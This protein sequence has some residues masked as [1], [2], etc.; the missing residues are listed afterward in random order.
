[1]SRL[2]VAGGLGAAPRWRRTALEVLAALA[3]GAALAA[4]FPAPDIGPLALVAL[5]PLLLLVETTRPVKAAA[6]G[7][8]AG[9]TFFG[10]HLLWIAQFLSWT[11]AVAWLAWGA[12]SA[13]QAAFIAAFFALVPAT[14]R[15]G[16]W[17]LLVLPAC[18][19]VLELVRAHH[20]MGGFPWGLLAISQHDAGPLLPLAR[21]IGGFGL[22]AVIVA[23]NLAVAFWLN[24]LLA[25]PAL[26]GDGG[27]LAGRGQRPQGPEEPRS[28]GWGR[29]AALAGLPVLAAGLLAARVAVPAAPA[30]SGPPMDVV[31]VQGGLRG[32][33]GL[34]QGLTTERVFANH[35]RLTETVALIPGDPP[36][37]VVWGEGAADADP[38][39]SPDRL[40]EVGRAA[41]A[42]KA[43]ILLGATTRVD[44]THRATEGLLFTAGGQLA[45]RYRKRRLVPF[46]EFVPLGG[47]LG[48]L[49][50]ATREGVPYDKVPGRRLE[51][52]LIDGVPVGTLI[53][54]ESA[55]PGDAR[56]LT[57][58][59]ARVLLIMTN[60]ASFGT[61]AGPRQHLAAGQLRAVEAGRTIVQAAVTGIS[62]V[63]EPTGATRQETGLYRETVLRAGL[64]PRDGRTLYVRYGRGIEAGLVGVAVGG[65]VLSG[66]LWWRRRPGG[67]G[68]PGPS[69]RLREAQS[70]GRRARPAP[71]AQT[72]PDRGDMVPPVRK[73]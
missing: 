50:P 28:G 27:P 66:L 38:L 20:P 37:L 71:N 43:P 47:L 42:A 68:R 45:D 23:V 6:L 30:P 25:R 52:L 19:A 33:R 49:I 51:P 72:V 65:M 70:A 46:G 3:S 34:A 59:G 67:V 73:P 1:M 13:I 4:A 55:Y 2:R 16:A 18:W 5:V 11:G 40:A 35:V 8:L 54:W 26:A 48:R 14:R 10:L 39:A 36:D 29:W 7:Y 12:L 58:D 24:A 44:D 21:V 31:V 15:L 60:N 17:R 61:G 64:S 69:A 53:C 62:A 63:I 22:A 32:G 56:Q 9:L 41:A 57:R